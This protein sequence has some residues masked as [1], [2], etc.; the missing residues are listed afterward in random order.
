MKQIAVL[1]LCLLLCGCGPI[2]ETLPPDTSPTEA[3]MPATQ[4]AEPESPLLR[5]P[6]DGYIQGIRPMGSDL[7]V[8]SSDEST[9][10]T[11]LRGEDLSVAAEI[12]LTIS[13]YP[14]DSCFRV[15]EDGVTY[16]DETSQEL[17][18][19]DTNLLEQRRLPLPGDILSAPALGDEIFYLVPGA[20]RALDP[21]TG[22]D[23][24]VKEYTFSSM[25][26]TEV[27]CNSTVLEC[28]AEHEDGYWSQMFLS[29][30]DGSLLYELFDYVTLDSYGD[31]YFVLHMDGIYEEK[32]LGYASQGMT[33]LQML[34]CPNPSAL[35]FPL[36]SQNGILTATQA[37]ADTVIDYYDITDGSHRYAITLQGQDLPWEVVSTPTSRYI[38]LCGYD[39]PK[40]TYTLFRW[41]PE[42]TPVQDDT[43]YIGIRW[44]AENPDTFGLS[45]IAQ[46][47]ARLSEKHGV[48]ILTW[49]DALEMPPFDYHLVPECQVPTLRQ[50]LSTLD[51]ALSH[52]PKEMLKLAAEDM[53]NG[54]LKIRLVRSLWGIA[55]Y[56]TLDTASGIQFWDDEGSTNIALAMESSLEQNFYHEIYHVLESRIY[57]HSDA[58]DNWDDLNPSGFSYD[59]NYSDYLDHDTEESYA[60]LSG[61]TQAFIDLYSMSYPKEDRA[62]IL[63]YAMMPDYSYNFESSIMQ[64]KLRTLCIGI[65][66]AYD[67]PPEE[68][69]RWEQHLCRD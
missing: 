32:L 1:I 23:R 58:L 66:E 7:L 62:R 22:A 53:G 15:R 55:E 29:T 4:A 64:D 37:G 8:V 40:Q 14:S 18:F 48:T 19:L 51:Q 5:L 43:A 16:Y 28:Y 27:H 26:L 17:V 54:I 65:R 56:D 35:A 38:W 45:Q 2:P 13:L 42:L 61:T 6:L 67:L 69:F 24:L 44:S 3:T 11:L 41:I 36:L 39:Y 21:E 30:K 46:E 60:L 34:H 47:A 68:T 31:R 12:T 63:E 59:Y 33:D 52:F 9:T 10:L 49:T 25:T 57:A 50:A 20:I